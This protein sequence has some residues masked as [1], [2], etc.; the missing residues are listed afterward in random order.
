VRRA[1][2][3]SVL[4]ACL[5]LVAAPS[6]AASTGPD[7]PKA[8]AYLVAPSQLIDGH[9]YEA[10]AGSG[11]A[12]FSLVIDGGFAL[13][14]T[15]G[16]DTALTSLVTFLSTGGKDGAGRTVDD[17]TGIGTAFASGGSIGKEALLAEVVGA[18]P[19]AFG[20]HDL[21]A[22]LDASV[23]SAVSVAPDTSCAAVGNYRYSPSVFSQAL[24]VIAQLRAGESAA[25]PLAY[26]QGLQ[27]ADG[28]WPSLIPDTGDS[29]VDST[30]M[31]L[32]ALALVPGT[33][34]AVAKG[35]AWIA[36]QQETDGGFPGA[37]GDSTNSTALALQGLSLDAT[38][39][40]GQIAHGLAFLAARQSTD[41]GFEV[42]AGGQ[43][44][45]DVRASTQAV[46][47]AVGT[48][49]GVLSRALGTGSP[50]PTP[51]PSPTPT[52]TPSPTPTPTPSAT[53]SATS[54]ASGPTPSTRVS[55][56]VLAAAGDPTLPATG[57]QAGGTGVAATLLLC[58]GGVLLLAARRVRRH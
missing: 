14:A 46:S 1:L 18:N 31:A 26:L 27:H 7:L 12:D 56:T 15:G 47:G 57:S 9:Y 54:T 6:A 48:S 10:F 2:R 22:A 41:G 21:L 51:T 4:S 42:A 19:R 5:L 33:S 28:S 37:A 52:P 53:P 13:A 32:M 16:D 43:P 11:F 50:T 55:A 23:C 38:T 30:G 24:G 20:G 45:S 39:Y 44:G 25:A 29:D 40:A 36:G 49:F 17:W 34:A 3:A 58:V 8:V 35:E